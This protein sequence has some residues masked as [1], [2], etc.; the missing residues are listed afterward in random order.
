MSF[1]TPYVLGMRQ[2]LPLN[3]SDVMVIEDDN[4][5]S[6]R[7]DQDRDPEEGIEDRDSH[8]GTS[9]AGLG[10]VISERGS[11]GSLNWIMITRTAAGR[12]AFKRPT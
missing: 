4:K 7:E 8:R 12:C 11:G 10:T 9:L 2:H 1:T 3:C 5:A 6:R